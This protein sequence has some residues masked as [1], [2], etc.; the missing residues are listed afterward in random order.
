MGQ[1]VGDQ[2]DGVVQAGGADSLTAGCQLGFALWRGIG[3]RDEPQPGRRPAM[4]QKG[5]CRH[6][7]R[8]T[9]ARQ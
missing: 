5:H 1:E 3:G 9:L 7:L 8:H 2:L 4:P 6:Q